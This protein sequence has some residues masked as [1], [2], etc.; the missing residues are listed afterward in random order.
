MEAN[1]TDESTLSLAA[2]LHEAADHANGQPITVAQL[3]EALK[4]RGVGMVLIVLTL[5]FLVPV[6][7]MGLSVPAGL[8]IALYGLTLSL[9]LRPWLPKFILNRH[10]SPKALTRITHIGERLEKLLKPRLKFMTWPGINSVLGLSLI[11]CGVCMALPLPIPFTNAVPAFAIVLLLAGLIA[12][13]GVFVLLGEFMT[14]ASAGFFGWLGYLFA[15]KGTSWLN[16]AV[17]M[18]EPMVLAL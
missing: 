5:P 2:A 8:A 17:T 12:R 15:K 1:N 14:L 13:D 7:T 11:L 10:I 4:E 16:S 6:P 3:M 9:H 18:A